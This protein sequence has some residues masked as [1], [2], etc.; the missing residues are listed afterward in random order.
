MDSRDM[1]MNIRGK[2]PRS[3]H[4]RKVLRFNMFTHFMTKTI[5]PVFL[6]EFQ[7]VERLHDEKRPLVISKCGQIAFL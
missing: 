4:L 6:D 5:I 2:S 3:F 7:R 1:L